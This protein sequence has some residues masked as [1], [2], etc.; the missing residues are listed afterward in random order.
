MS[1]E[2]IVTKTL[3]KVEFDGPIMPTGE[4]AHTPCTWLVECP[5]KDDDFIHCDDC[6]ALADLET[7]PTN[8]A[9]SLMLRPEAKAWW[10]KQ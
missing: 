4:R 2:T 3:G 10:E 9:L 7:C 1:T 8:G 5:R 6:P